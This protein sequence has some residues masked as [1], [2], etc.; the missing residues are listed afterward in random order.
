MRAVCM[1]A[2]LALLAAGC[3]TP[4]V[5]DTTPATS[6][7]AGAKSDSS[8]A[9]SAPAPMQF[10]SATRQWAQDLFVA[11]HAT[12]P[13]RAFDHRKMPDGRAAS[14]SRVTRA[15]PL[16]GGTGLVVWQAHLEDYGGVGAS[17]GWPLPSFVPTNADVAAVRSTADAM[18][19]RFTTLNATARTGVVSQI[20]YQGYH[21]DVTPH[22]ATIPTT[23][24]AHDVNTSLM[25]GALA[26][27]SWTKIPGAGVAGWSAWNATSGA[28][29]FVFEPEQSHVGA[30]LDAAGD[31][32]PGGPDERGPVPF[33]SWGLTARSNGL[34]FLDYAAKST[35]PDVGV[36][37]RALRASLTARGFADA[38][39]PATTWDFCSAKAP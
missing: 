8:T 29:T 1:V 21:D 10:C 17:I 16:S 33:Y 27:A 13:D 25:Q 9:S 30:F 2:M 20:G 24:R 12:G 36:P 14:T 6:A 3:A 35:V 19:Q 11:G 22:T 15:V 39:V 31:L 7:A 32:F 38:P 18:L 34:A 23:L 26:Q 37:D 4:S 28:D 5:N